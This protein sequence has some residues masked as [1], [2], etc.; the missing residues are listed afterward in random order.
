MIGGITKQDIQEALKTPKGRELKEKLLLGIITERQFEK[1]ILNITN[2]TKKNKLTPEQEAVKKDLERLLSPNNYPYSFLEFANKYI[3]IQSKTSI[4]SKHGLNEHQVEAY[5]RICEL[6]KESGQEKGIELVIIKGRQN[7]ISTFVC[8]M[9]AIYHLL[10]WGQNQFF[11]TNI[12][13]NANI[14]YNKF[15]IGF[16]NLP[17]V[18]EKQIIGSRD[19]NYIK[20]DDFALIFHGTNEGSGHRS[21]KTR[22]ATYSFLFDDEAGHRDKGED[23]TSLVNSKSKVRIVAGTPQAGSMLEKIL[24]EKEAQ[25]KMKEVLFLPWYT[26]KEY[27]EQITEDYKPKEETLNYLK[28]FNIENLSLEKIKWAETVITKYKEEAFNPYV[29]FSQEYP[30]DLWCGFELTAEDCFTEPY[31]IQ[32]AIENKTAIASNVAVIGVDVSSTT[33]KT[34][35]CVRYGDY[36]FFKELKRNANAIVDFTNKAGQICDFI[37]SLPHIEFKSINI[38]STGLGASFPDIMTQE[39]NKRGLN[40]NNQI[41]ITP[42]HFANTIGRKEDSVFEARK[43]GVKEY[44]YFEL[45]KWLST[46]A[47]RLDAGEYN[48]RLQ[49]ELLATS[50]TSENGEEKLVSKEKIKRKISYSPDFADAL[51]LTFYPEK[52]YYFY[53]M[54]S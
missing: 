45:R 12:L 42:V 4:V 23:I 48:S 49:S 25:G 13:S 39:L 31:L 21:S 3:Y 15:K 16:S 54:P 2:K 32:K 33:D 52:K 24:K 1:T 27:E 22:G 37:A 43:I 34:V 28:K 51:A 36:A 18:N 47:V 46:E 20:F 38:D 9:F 26:F 5:K 50:I 8:G 29:K 30:S 11:L 53:K 41:T 7:G 40:Y 35:M 17:D 44:M 19:G 6:Y 14:L 10:V